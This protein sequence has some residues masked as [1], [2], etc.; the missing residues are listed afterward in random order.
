MQFL[1][2]TGQSSSG[3]A[4]KAITKMLF[5]HL[6]IGHSHFRTE[7]ISRFTFLFFFIL[8]LS[9]LWLPYSGHGVAFRSS[10]KIRGKS[11]FSDEAQTGTAWLIVKW[12]DS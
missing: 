4:L 5:L 6:G 1:L 11:F 10:K 3:N 12:R 7:T 9:P 8:T 2:L